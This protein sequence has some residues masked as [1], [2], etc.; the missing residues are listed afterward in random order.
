MLKDAAEI[1]QRFTAE[2]YVAASG[3]TLPY[4]FLAPP[5]YDASRR[6]PLV[7]CLHGAAGRGTDNMTSISGS[8]AARVLSQPD[9]RTRYPSFLL[10]P[11]A[12]PDGCWGHALDEAA[13]A[14]RVRN[15]RPT[16]PAVG[17]LV[18]ELMER[19]EKSWSIDTDRVYVIGQ[20]MGGGGTWHLMAE[21]PHKFAAAIAICGPVSTCYADVFAH[22]PVW[23]FHGELDDHTPVQRIRDIVAAIRTAGGSVRY[24]EYEGVGHGS[25]GL[26][27]QDPDVL[28]WLFAQRRS[29]GV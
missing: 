2:T 13:M 24:T 9:M 15:G 19:T 8:V 12:P 3:E 5:D 7:L 1:A 17:Y 21:R 11:Q 22:T 20:S 28:E 16:K 27:F 18:L 14:E 10:V 26:V 4:L 25:M 29:K 23:A 6:Y